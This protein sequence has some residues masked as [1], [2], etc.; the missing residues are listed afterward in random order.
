[1]KLLGLSKVQVAIGTIALV[2]AATILV[3]WRPTHPIRISAEST[4]ATTASH[5]PP[6][7]AAAASKTLPADA[8]LNASADQ[9]GN[10]V[11]HLTIVV[12]ESGRPISFASVEYRAWSGEDFQGQKQL[13][14]NRLGVREVAYP[15]NTT[16]L[17][18]TTQIEGLAAIIASS[19][20]R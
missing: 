14:A 4:K 3:T 7:A 9:S 6:T 2:A 13:T 8:S 16:E 18:L 17:Q 19:Y 5:T 10:L 15:S 11:L 20:R 1:V 12:K